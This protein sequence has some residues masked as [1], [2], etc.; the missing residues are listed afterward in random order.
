MV[1]RKLTIVL[2]AVCL[3]LT[4]CVSN[5]VKITKEQIYFKKYALSTCL[6]QSFDYSPLKDDAFIA[7]DA[8][9]QKGN[10]PLEAYDMLEVLVDEWRNKNYTTKDGEQV[11]IPKCLDLYE[12][13]DLYNLY[14]KYTPCKEPD[15]WLSKE[16][17]VESCK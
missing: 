3:A 12:S 9:L 16:R 2:A 11:R 14:Q 8:Y 6:H 7:V 10:M 15:S 13:K 5:E 4:A 1:S 17:Y